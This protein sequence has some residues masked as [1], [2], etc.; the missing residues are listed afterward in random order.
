[1]SLSMSD[2]G[3][4][5]IPLIAPDLI[6]IGEDGRPRFRVG[7]CRAC[8]TLS[9]P[10]APVCGSCLSEDIGIE[11]AEGAGELYAYSVVHQAPRG[12]VVPYALG[13]VDL[14]NGLRILGHVVGDF[15][16]LRSG[17]PVKLGLGTVRLTPDGEPVGSYIFKPAD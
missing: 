4:G 15:T 5:A 10:A 12:W 9:F 6:D 7:R 11:V 16:K 17:L 3:A 8:G 1:M 14:P 13:Y 2:A